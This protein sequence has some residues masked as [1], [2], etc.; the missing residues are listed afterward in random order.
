MAIV[1]ARTVVTLL[2]P[3]GMSS[4]RLEGGTGPDAQPVPLGSSHSK[5]ISPALHN[6]TVRRFVVF[7]PIQ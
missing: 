4:M 1:V 6:T 7:L 2:V 3:L 5:G